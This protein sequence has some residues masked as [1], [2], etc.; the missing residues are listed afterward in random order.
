MTTEQFLAL[1][2]DDRMTMELIDGE[3]RQR[4]VTTRNPKHSNTMTRFSFA[5][6]S[7]LRAQSGMVGHA[8]SGEIRCR[9]GR[10]P[11]TVVGID[12]ALFVGD[13]AMGVTGESAY[14]DGAPLI[15]VE[16]LSP[17]DTHEQIAVK[18]RRY[19]DAGTKQVWVA[20]PDFRTVMVHRTGQPPRSFA[21]DQT[22]KGEPDLPG[23]KAAVSELFEPNL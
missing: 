17:S 21:E 10:N 5:L 8:P 1:P 15:A 22:L 13:V 16:I 3:L 9:L 19:L 4:R 7:W 2:A 12:V 11:D 23:F 6:F 20:D 14:Y 18:I